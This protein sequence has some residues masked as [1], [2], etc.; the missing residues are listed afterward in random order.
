MKRAVLALL[1]AFGLVVAFVATGSAVPKTY[2]FTGTVKTVSGT[3]FSVEKSAKETWEFE[4]TADTKG[5]PA[6]GDKVTVTYRMV[7][8]TITKK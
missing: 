7:A 4:T 1:L 6:V 8:T 5:K 2:Q 3:T